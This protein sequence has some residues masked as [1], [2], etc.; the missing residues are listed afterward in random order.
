MKRKYAVILFVALLFTTAGFVGIQNAD[1]FLQVKKSIDLFGSVYKD[2]IENYV[3]QIDPEQVMRGGI[4][5][6]LSML[7]PYTVY[8]DKT[9]S[10]E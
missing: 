9:T 6:M 8:M 1:T 4:N 7:D 2:V 10:S 5:G 3:D